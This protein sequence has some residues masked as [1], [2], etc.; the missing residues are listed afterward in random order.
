MR[1]LGTLANPR[2]L[3]LECTAAKI[4]VAGPC[5]LTALVQL[6]HLRLQVRLRM[7]QTMGEQAAMAR[8]STA[9]RH[10]S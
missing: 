1:L 10:A 2:L 3:S 5:W 4:L 6:R 8:C 7:G 9:Q